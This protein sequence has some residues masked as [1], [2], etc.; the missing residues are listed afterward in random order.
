MGKVKLCLGCY[1]YSEVL[2]R[3]FIFLPLIF[4]G[5]KLKF[6]CSKLNNYCWLNDEISSS[7]SKSNWLIFFQKMC[8]R[9]RVSVKLAQNALAA[10]SNSKDYYDR[11]TKKTCLIPTK[12]PNTV[13][14][15]IHRL[16]VLT[17]L[18]LGTFGSS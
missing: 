11:L 14:A 8:S 13:V 10:Q 3:D 2:Y 5:R 15:V 16:S 6:R 9:I 7:S 12:W 4:W 18:G 1:R 17:V